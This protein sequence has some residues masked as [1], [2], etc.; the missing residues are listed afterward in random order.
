M[1][2]SPAIRPE[3]TGTTVFS[4]SAGN[5]GEDAPVAVFVGVGQI[6]SR[7]PTTDTH[8]IRRRPP[9]EQTGLDAAQTL[10]VG[11]LRE[12]HR[13]KVIVGRERTRRPRHRKSSRRP[14][15]LHLI[16]ACDDLGEDGRTGIHFRPRM[17][18]KPLSPTTSATRPS[19]RY[20]QIKRLLTKSPQALNWTGVPIRLQMPRA[21]GRFTVA[22]GVRRVGRA[23]PASRRGGARC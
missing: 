8:A 19:L 2:L 6:R 5:L 4:A 10:P 17:A 13:G 15:Q 21:R 11:Q 7:H 20:S 22:A 16:Q 14:R 3:A 12:H 23:T 9:P 1:R 18:D